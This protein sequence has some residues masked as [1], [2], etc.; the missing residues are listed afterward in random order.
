MGSKS[1]GQS[2]SVASAAVAGKVHVESNTF[3]DALTKPPSLHGEEGS[4]R[5]VD[6]RKHTH[7]RGSKHRGSV[8][9][10]LRSPEPGASAKHRYLVRPLEGHSIGAQQKQ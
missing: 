1:L 5:C 7:A 8:T 3:F 9:Q 10:L 4:L 2:S 6:V